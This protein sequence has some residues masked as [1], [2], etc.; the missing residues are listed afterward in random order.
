M[1]DTE[2]LPTPEGENSSFFGGGEATSRLFTCY[3]RSPSPPHKSTGAR[4]LTYFTCSSCPPLTRWL[5]YSRAPFT[6]YL[7]R[8]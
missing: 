7:Y 8:W 3:V 4:Y 5:D 6:L 2:N 1:K